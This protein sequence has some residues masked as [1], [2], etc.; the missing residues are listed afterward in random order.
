MKAL[1]L[2]KNFTVNSKQLNKSFISNERL[3]RA[4]VFADKIEKERFLVAE[5]LVSQFT[6]INLGIPAPC[7]RGG[8]GEKPYIEDYPDISVSR[9]YA[10]DCLAIAVEQPHKIGIDC[11]EVKDFDSKVM[12]Y[13]FTKKEQ[14]YIKTSKFMN[15]AFSLMWTRKESY[16]KCIGRGID[17][18]INI[19]DVT[20]TKN[21]ENNNYLRPIF[22]QNDKINECFVNSYILGKHV[23]SVC[24]ECNDAFPKINQINKEQSYEQNDTRLF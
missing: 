18:P 11:E 3:K 7:F 21:I 17:Y 23:I 8:I 19:L 14:E 5:Q 9:S 2:I 24:S 22:I 15:T 20:P 4:E 1:A 12:K 13:F 6:S 16:I 10:G